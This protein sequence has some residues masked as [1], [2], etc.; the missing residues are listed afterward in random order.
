MAIPDEKLFAAVAPELTASEALYDRALQVLPG[1]CSRNT[2][3]REPHP[4]YALHGKGCY[5]TDVEGVERIDFANNMASLIHGHVFAPIVDAVNK[6]LKRGTA[7]TL[8]TEV[9]I[10]YAEELCER[11]PGFEMIRFVNSGTEAVM[12]AI[13]ASRAFT[14]RPKIA[15]VEGAYHGSYDFAEV[16]QTATPANWGEVDKPASVPVSFGTPKSA[17]DD[18]VVIPF[19]DPHR[20]VQILEEHASELACVL[21]DLIPHRVGLM[22]ATDHFLATIRDWTSTNGSLLVCDEVITFRSTLGGAQQNYSVRPD[23]TALGKMIGGGFP[24]GALAGRRD[25]MSVMDPLREPLLFPHSGTFSANPITMTAGR[26]AMKYFDEVAVDNLNVL[27][28]RARKQI[29]EAIRLADVRAC[30]T[31]S[32][33]MFRVLMKQT[34]PENYRDAFASADEAARLKYFLDF[35]FANGVMLI[36]T[37]TGM[38]STA[39]RASEIDWLTEVVLDGLVQ[40]RRK[41]GQ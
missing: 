25:V 8:A 41:F 19:N 2:V 40:T 18:V 9:E 32:G 38:L 36:N 11:V 14:G 4:V 16:S 33:S 13:K 3:L 26:T 6:Q 24:V 28:A 27:G 34:P 10:Q 29:K 21:V 37:G 12:G 22:P 30:V 23:L 39:M 31:G 15:K 7:Y 17:L 20:A 5:V 35:M 1:G